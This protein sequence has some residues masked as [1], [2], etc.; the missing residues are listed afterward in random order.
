M[1]KLT[2]VSFVEDQTFFQGLM[3]LTQYEPCQNA[4][5]AKFKATDD[6]GQIKSLDCFIEH[7]GKGFE[8]T[9]VVGEKTENVDLAN[10]KFNLLHKENCF[11]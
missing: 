9:S 11:L 10:L 7:D 5:I 3:D 2:A 4:I 8:I 6:K 1:F